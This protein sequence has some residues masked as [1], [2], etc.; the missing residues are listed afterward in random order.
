MWSML[1][2]YFNELLIE[3]GFLVIYLL[4]FYQCDEKEKQGPC[5]SVLDESVSVSQSITFR[6]E[7]IVMLESLQFLVAHTVQ[8]IK[9][10]QHS[11]SEEFF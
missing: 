4:T 7:F 10:F 1:Q 9:I 5:S 2:K 8:R 11:E 6:S 3:N